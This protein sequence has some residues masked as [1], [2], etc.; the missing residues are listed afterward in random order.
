MDP[1]KNDFKGSGKEIPQLQEDL[2]LE[3]QS[4]GGQR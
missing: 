2:S 3:T 1:F 4:V